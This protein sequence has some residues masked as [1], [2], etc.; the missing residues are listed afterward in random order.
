MDCIF[1]LSQFPFCLHFICNFSGLI[2]TNSLIANHLH[3]QILILD[4]TPFTHVM[5]IVYARANYL[6]TDST[7]WSHTDYGHTQHFHA[8]I[9][10]S[11]NYLHHTWSHP[12]ITDGDAPTL[13]LLQKAT[14]LESNSIAYSLILDSYGV[15]RYN[16]KCL[17]S[18]DSLLIKVESSWRL[19]LPKLLSSAYSLPIS[20]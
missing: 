14:M 11:S 10:T 18:G 9:F 13:I 8:T 4:S 3:S 7:I 17:A 12:S 20:S 6:C 15:S 5:L 2:L 16:K 1:L 19:Q